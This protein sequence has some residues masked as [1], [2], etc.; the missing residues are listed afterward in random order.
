MIFTM[1][2]QSQVCTRMHDVLGTGAPVR[3]PD[4]IALE[5]GSTFTVLVA[6][7]IFFRVNE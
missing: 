4:P 6:A 7:L 1:L 5:S 3:R 2:Y